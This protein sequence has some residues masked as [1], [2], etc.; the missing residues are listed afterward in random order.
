MKLVVLDRDGVINEDST[1]FVRAP[2]DIRPLPGSLEAIARLSN[3]EYHVVVATNQSGL[4]RGL[5]D[6][7]TLNAIHDRLNHLL[8]AIGGH[9]D[10]WFFCPHGPEAG[11]F[12]R[13]P[14]PG[15]LH[16]IAARLRTSLE[17][18]PVVGDSMR[19]LE[20]ARA[21]GARPVLVR[22]G[23][24]RDL[25]ATGAVLSGVQIHDDLAAFV[26][27]ELGHD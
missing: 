1:E 13:K 27:C 25:E 18:V 16:D 2:E 24:G 10:A 11:C 22:T 4:A 26:D 8:A 21:V 14:R 17:G 20:A 19:D 6:I 15:M 3:A 12:C 7:G 5:F 23:N 9:V